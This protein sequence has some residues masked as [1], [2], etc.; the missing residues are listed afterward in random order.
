MTT[1]IAWLDAQADLNSAHGDIAR[2]IAADRKRNCLT[3][4][5]PQG[6]REHIET[7][8]DADRLALLA[9]D[10]ATHEWEWQEAWRECEKNA[11][12]RIQ[13]RR[14]K[15]WRKPAGAIV[16]AR[17][18]RWGNPFPVADHGASRAVELFR[19]HVT[20]DPELLSAVRAELA[21]KQLCC[22]CP[23]DAPCHAD[24]LLELANSEP[25][26]A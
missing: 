11:P 19:E 26:Q 8:H 5:S 17:P 16:V 12:R 6:I 2:D 13:L 10:R 22:W 23:L 7:E 14:T 3:A 21:G 15:G 20:A 9:L 18:T 24:V 25:R 4:D 1:F